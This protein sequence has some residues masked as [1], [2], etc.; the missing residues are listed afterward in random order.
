MPEKKHEVHRS[1]SLLVT[2]R[3]EPVSTNRT[4]KEEPVKTPVV[5]VDLPETSKTL[6]FQPD[7]VKELK[8][9]LNRMT[10]VLKQ[11]STKIQQ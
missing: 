5:L 4:L 3:D 1:V 11:Y 2:P 7:Q 10:S 6:K 9:V 8:A